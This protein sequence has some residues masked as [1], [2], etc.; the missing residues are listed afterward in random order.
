[1]AVDIWNEIT[2]E[3]ADKFSISTEGEGRNVIPEEIP[4]VD[5]CKHLVIVGLKRAFE[6]A[7]EVPMPPVRVSTRNM[8]RKSW[9]G[10][11]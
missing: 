10:P 6:F 8:V 3:R 11:S 5:E 9:M 7:G 4:N 2:V 1:M